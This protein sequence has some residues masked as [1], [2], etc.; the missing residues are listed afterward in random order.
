VEF[1]D[2]LGLQVRA[3][4]STDDCDDFDDDD[5]DTTA[6]HIVEY[7][8]SGPTGQSRSVS[9][10]SSDDASSDCDDDDDDDDDA[11]STTHT[12]VEPYVVSLVW[13]PV[14]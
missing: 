14:M 4:L 11:T 10:V 1:Q 7:M 2:L 9:G 8:S 12:S 5:D 13:L 3:E 6:L